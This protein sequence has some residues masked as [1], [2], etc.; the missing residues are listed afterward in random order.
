M[1][2]GLERRVVFGNTTTT[3]ARQD[4]HVRRCQLVRRLDF[5]RDT[6]SDVNQQE[7][8]IAQAARQASRPARLYAAY[9]AQWWWRAASDE[10]MNE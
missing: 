9:L 10:S 6:I 3:H 7:Y 2:L 8:L 5:I 4:R 1:A